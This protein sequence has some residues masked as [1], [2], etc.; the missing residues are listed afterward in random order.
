MALF[1]IAFPLCTLIAAAGILYPEFLV[2]LASAVTEFLFS[3]LDWF[4]MAL[5][6]GLLGLC[7]WLALGRHGRLKLGAPYEE[8]EFS[9]I[10]WLA[11]LFAAGMG[12]GLLFWGVAE[13]MLHYS[14]TPIEEPGTPPAARD[15]LVITMF[16]WGLHAWA[17][18]AL[19]A[20]VLAYFGFRHNTA[21]MPGAPL[22]RA[23]SG[24]WVP[25]VAKLADL[26]AIM[27]VALGVAG[28]IGMG[29]LQLQSG[30]HVVTG[31]AT[32]SVWVSATL[33][34][35][36]VVSYM[37]SA[38]TGLN[39][40]IRLLSNLNMALAVVLLIFVAFAGPT[41]YL[42][43]G[44]VTSIGDYLTA[45]PGLSFQLYPYQDV[46]GWLHGWTMTYWIWWIAWAPFVGVFIARISRGRTIREFLV[47]VIAAPT[48]FSVLWFAVFGGLGIYEESFGAGGVAELVRQDIS[49]ALF[50][51]FD[52][53]PLSGVL[54]IVAILLV[55][56]FL[57]TSVDSATFVLGMMTSRGSLNPPM[58]R[59]VA[60][61]VVL[62]ALGGALMFSG[63]IEA[64]RAITILGAIP[65]AFVVILQGVAL[66]RTLRTEKGEG[67]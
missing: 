38:A 5:A 27:A 49:V 57:V 26:I 20:L 58:G 63:N 52:R 42:M 17:I 47:G 45:L 48:A 7:L 33:L 12:V 34:A 18:Y 13:P 56:V 54:S 44:F 66:L 65:F 59:K 11:M 64:L 28:S 1:V 24:R 51:M 22:I 31:L 10:S 36:L 35:L 41:S 23:F 61:G 62:G 19:S 8:P 21:Y 46:G 55:F 30:L 32:N 16:H 60:W 53:L 15:A 25:T 3:A 40:G 50:S 67:E 4:Y 6:T 2:A 37:A 39:K 9:T 43:R 14:Q 29:I